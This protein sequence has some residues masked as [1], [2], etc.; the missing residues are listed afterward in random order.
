MGEIRLTAKRLAWLECLLMGEAKPVGTVPYWCRKAG[1]S[2]F[3]VIA[4]DG[5]R[6]TAE[7][8][9]KECNGY[10]FQN[11]YEYLHPVREMITQKGREVLRDN[12]T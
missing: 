5:R 10:P 1:W 8:A 12:N 4:P 7:Q 3:V 11:G 9:R 2:A 6:I